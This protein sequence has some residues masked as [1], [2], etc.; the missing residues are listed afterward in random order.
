MV[1]RVSYDSI[2]LLDDRIIKSPRKMTVESARP[3]D[4]KGIC[5]VL[6]ANRDDPGLF[7]KP[8]S[9]VRATITEWLVARDAGGKVV[10]CACLHR[11]SRQLAEIHGVAVLPEFQGKGI[12]GALIRECQRRAGGQQI[13]KLWLATVKPEYFGRYGFRRFNRWNLPFATMRR[14]F[15]QV[16]DQPAR[17]WLPAL[18]GRHIFMECHLSSDGPGAESHAPSPATRML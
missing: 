5:S 14:K 11:E 18:F 7:Q 13:E 8:E 16:F 9:L 3:S 6:A 15:Q 12:G 1:R 2:A 17:R 4:A 10:G